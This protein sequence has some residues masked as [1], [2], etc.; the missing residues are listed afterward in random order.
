M[1]YFWHREASRKLKDFLIDKLYNLVPGTEEYQDTVF[2][3]AL[4]EAKDKK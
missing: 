2:K 4:V 1:D 3:L